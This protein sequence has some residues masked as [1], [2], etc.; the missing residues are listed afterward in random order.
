MNTFITVI[1]AIILICVAIVAIGFAV[2]LI[3]FNV[4]VNKHDRKIIKD[5]IEKKEKKNG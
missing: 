5:I 4:E 1:V 2:F 3:V